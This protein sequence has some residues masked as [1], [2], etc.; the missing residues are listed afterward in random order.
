VRHYE[1]G[2]NMLR[3]TVFA[4]LVVAAGSTSFAQADS[5]DL[6]YTG[7]SGGIGVTVT[8]G[9][10]FSAGH[11]NHTIYNG[12]TP[13]GS[14]QTFCIELGEFANNGISTY[15]IVDLTSAPDPD[16][17]GSTYSQAQA[18][19]VIDVIA[20]A[21]SLGWIDMSLQNAGGT[22][23]Q[24]SAI[25]ASIWG[26]LFGSASSSNGD[27]QAAIGTLSAQSLDSGTRSIMAKRLRAIVAQGEQDMLYVVPLPAPL[28]AGL[29][30]LGLAAGVRSVR[31][32]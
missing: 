3:N 11:M 28:W 13:A 17:G 22:S 10:T 21:V 26:A 14:F 2:T 27:V 8:P 16:L 6:E 4:A 31:R 7:I 25:Q 9:G 5:I 32:R 12:A 1:E 24:I 20:N 29:G 15:Q 30:M 18:D 23:A 19:A